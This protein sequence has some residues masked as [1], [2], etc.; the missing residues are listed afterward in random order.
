MTLLRRFGGLFARLANNRHAPRLAIAAM[1]QTVRSHDM[2]RRFL[3][4]FGVREN[5]LSWLHTDTAAS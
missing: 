3:T 5:Q 4:L 2:R 1:S